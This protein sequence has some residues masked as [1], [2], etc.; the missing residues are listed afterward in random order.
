MYRR[1]TATAAL[2]SCCG[3]WQPIIDDRFDYPQKDW[4]RTGFADP[5]VW[6]HSSSTD[7]YWLFGTSLKFFST[8]SFNSAGELELHWLDVNFTGSGASQFWA[9]RPFEDKKGELHAYATLSTGG[10]VRVAHFL[11]AAGQPHWSTQRP[12]TKWYYNRIIVPAVS[13]DSNVV[14]DSADTYF[15]TNKQFGPTPPTAWPHSYNSIIAQRMKDA[16]HLDEQSAPVVLLEPGKWISEFRDGAGSMKIVESVHVHKLGSYWALVYAVGDYDEANYKIGIAY[17]KS[18]LGPYKRAVA[19]DPKGVWPGDNA[20]NNTEVSYVL[21]TEKPAWQNCA[22]DSLNGP[23]IG[24]IV[25][26]VNGSTL[27]IFHARRRGVT[28]LGGNGRYVW[29]IKINVAIDES[30][31]MSQWIVPVLPRQAVPGGT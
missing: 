1:F 18:F 6:R 29:A 17:S 27:L 20:T 13:Y 25:Q 22:V 3:A 24:N 15:I 14:V 23:G 5:Y 26:L 4:G 16:A 10:S 11:P 28:H 30:K 9:F 21:Q 31:P 8:R 2:L 19:P 12:V 7:V